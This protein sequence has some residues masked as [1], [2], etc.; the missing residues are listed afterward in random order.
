MSS[1][2]FRTWLTAMLCAMGAFAQADDVKV[3][4]PNAVKESISTISARF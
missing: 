3:A 2:L 1:F 4:A